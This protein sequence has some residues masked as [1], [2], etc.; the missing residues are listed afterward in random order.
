[1]EAEVMGKGAGSK[2]REVA[3]WFWAVDTWFEAIVVRI[4][5]VDVIARFFG[6]EI[7][8]S[9]KIG[10]AEAFATCTGRESF[11]VLG[12]GPSREGE[13][14]CRIYPTDGYFLMPSTL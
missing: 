6:I 11:V 3:V 4:L 13:G 9:E 14:D 12:L 8:V 10:S 2:V 7:L 5:A 1:M